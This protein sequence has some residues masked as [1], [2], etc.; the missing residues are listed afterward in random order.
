[1]LPAR[2]SELQGK[3]APEDGIAAIC[4][5]ECTQR[6]RH[7]G[8]QFDRQRTGVRV[9]RS[10]PPRPQTGPH[11]MAKQLEAR[12]RHRRDA[13]LEPATVELLD[14]RLFEAVAEDRLEVALD[15]CATEIA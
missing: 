7:A 2:V 8:A 10:R 15:G 3:P 6:L 14:Q 13:R 5:Q 9:L 12:V 11:E 1:G 4:V